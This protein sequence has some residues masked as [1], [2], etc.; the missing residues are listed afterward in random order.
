M[1]LYRPNPRS[2][3]S[4]SLGSSPSTVYRVTRCVVAVLLLL[5]A[6]T[7]AGEPST[8]P[9]P[10]T[11][12]TTSAT[13]TAAPVSTSTTEPPVL[14]PDFTLALGDGGEFTLTGTDK[15]VYLI[16][17]AEW[18]PVCRKELPMIDRLAAE[19]SDRVDFVA[20]AWKSS[21]E[22][23]R[24]AVPELM[25]S[26]TIKWGLDNDQVIFALYEVPYQPVTVLIDTDRRVIDA[27]AGVRSEARIR[28]LLD[29]VT[30]AAG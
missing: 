15:P 18:C 1:E 19:Y 16:F 27:W 30:G 9:A 29:R 13:T 7:T 14:A 28:E 11:T 21:E 26:G 5:A 17:W 24:R 2:P 8:T 25:P 3:G 4:R 22:L 10:S 20:P 23:T 12:A 6:C